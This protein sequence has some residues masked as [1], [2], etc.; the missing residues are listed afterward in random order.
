VI[1]A[2]F[3]TLDAAAPS[4]RVR[5]L[6]HLAG[7][8]RAGV[9]GEVV[10][11]PRGWRARRRRLATLD[12]DVVVLLRVLLGEGDL[13]RLRRA[14]AGL[15]L[16]VDDAVTVRPGGRPSA[17][18]RRR[19]LATLRAVDLV[20]AGSL[21]L[22][23][24]AARVHPRVRLIPPAS[25]SGAPPRTAAGRGGPFRAV[26]TGSRHTLP[27]LEA[28]GPALLEAA[29]RVPSL[30][31]V[32]LAD[33]PP[34]L[35]GVRVRFVPWSAAAEDEAL[36]S[37]DVGLYPLPQDRWAA[38]KCA[39]KVRRYM[40]FGLPTVASGVG[41]GGEALDAGGLPAGVLVAGGP[42]GRWAEALASLAADPARR[43]RLGRLAR[44]TALGRDALCSRTRTLVR[45]LREAAAIGERRRG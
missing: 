11:L 36:A 24:D 18:L 33:R 26:W 40:A 44:S 15:V 5:V 45:V 19:Y 12:H 1:R 3:V 4:T 38:G 17:R 41:G 9:R 32:V 39:Y 25:P 31:L 34:R 13:V 8:A 22:R 6:D 29:R 7:L 10:V 16:D 20:V 2:A 37:A 14:A 30:E 27:Y 21:A 28:L 42:G 43:A 23:E 35:P